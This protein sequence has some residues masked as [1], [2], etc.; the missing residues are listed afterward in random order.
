MRQVVV[1]KIGTDLVHASRGS[2]EGFPI[3]SIVKEIC[4][5][6]KKTTIDFIIV[7]SGA[8]GCGI[9]LLGIKERPNELSLRQALA[10]IGQVELMQRYSRLLK[11]YSSNKIFPAQILLTASDLDNR[12]SYINILNTIHKLLDLG[13]AIPIINEND[14]VA[15]EEIKFGDNDTLSA[16]IA[17]RINATQL[18]LLTDVNGLYTKNPKLASDAELITEVRT[19]SP[20]IFAYAQGTNNEYSVG[21]MLTKLEAVKITWRAGIPTIIA[22]GYEKRV[23]SKIL[24]GEANC[25]RFLPPASELSY[26]KRW[27]A[28]GKTVKGKIYIDDGAKNALLKKGSSLLPVGITSVEGNFKK[29]DCVSI[30][31]SSGDEIGRGIVNMGVDELLK[32]KGKKTSEIK[33]QFPE[34]DIEEAIHRDNMILFYN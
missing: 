27:I 12:A 25:T 15:T 21:G 18:I 24:A 2:K 6:K 4:E 7:S 11:L 8:I 33:K 32:V 30:Y 14:T 28:F 17:V 23:L 9:D 20:Q 3:K 13:N 22:N 1:V 29:G 34:L 19:L 10:S 5:I 31:S 26:R 16:K